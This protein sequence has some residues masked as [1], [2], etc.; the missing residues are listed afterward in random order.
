MN[1]MN[2]G[3]TMIGQALAFCIHQCGALGQ[4]LAACIHMM[5]GH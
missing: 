4:E 1:G 3:V 5:L 2:G